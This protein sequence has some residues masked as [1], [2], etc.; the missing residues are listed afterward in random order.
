MFYVVYLFWCE[1]F[2]R[3]VF[4]M[5]FYSANK[6]KIEGYHSFDR[7]KSSRLGFLV[8]LWV[9]IYVIYGKLFVVGADDYAFNQEILH[10][11]SIWFNSYLLLSILRA[12]FFWHKQFKISKQQEKVLIDYSENGIWIMTI[13]IMV[14][15]YIGLSF[16]DDFSYDSVLVIA[17]PFVV[18]KTLI[19]YNVIRLHY[20]NARQLAIQ[21]TN[22]AA[23]QAKEKV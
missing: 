5:I 20:K 21:D 17:L 9:L 2:I 4:E 6:H 19:E 14:G 12:T 10:F 8:V 15:T 11:K 3:Y 13:S 23:P 22:D 16:L 7:Y 1:E 18:L